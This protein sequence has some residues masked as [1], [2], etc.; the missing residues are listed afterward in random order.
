MSSRQQLLGMIP[1]KHHAVVIDY[2]R[3]GRLDP[4]QMLDDLRSVTPAVRREARGRLGTILGVR[5]V[6]LRKSTTAEAK[7]SSLG[8]KVPLLELMRRPEDQGKRNQ[9]QLLRS[10]VLVNKDFNKAFGK[11]LRVVKKD[12][13]S[14]VSLCHFF[15]LTRQ[16]PDNDFQ[17]K[18]GV[19]FILDD[20][21]IG[22]RSRREYQ[23]FLSDEDNQFHLFRH[24][25]N[26]SHHMETQRFPNTKEGFIQLLDV[27]VPILKASVFG[28]RP[29]WGL[30][31]PLTAFDKKMLKRFNIIQD[32]TI[33][34]INDPS[35]FKIDPE[36][37]SHW[38]MSYL[39][40]LSD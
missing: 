31:R 39:N 9:F 40:Q 30:L 28:I 27:F 33:R 20:P 11:S 34:E 22:H 15:D 12:I 1:K 38:D 29:Y 21:K 36:T 14:V 26:Q 23:I 8:H 2:I 37:I 17:H 24:D 3:E 32:Q 10:L 18:V 6:H 5:R 19:S 4:R 13:K 7:G 25:Y 16:F 35:L